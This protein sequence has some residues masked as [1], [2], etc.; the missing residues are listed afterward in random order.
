MPKDSRPAQQWARHRA[1]LDSRIVEAH[2]DRG[3]LA[4]P[5]LGSAYLFG[6]PS[7]QARVREPRTCFFG[8]PSDPVLADP[9][10]WVSLAAQQIAQLVQAGALSLGQRVE[11]A[12]GDLVE[13]VVQLGLG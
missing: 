8:R 3:G 7:E 1:E 11:A 2:A 9:E 12:L 10:E 5:V 6:Q 13:Q 4:L